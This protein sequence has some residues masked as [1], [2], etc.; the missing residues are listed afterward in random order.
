M[1]SQFA[2]SPLSLSDH[3]RLLKL[4]GD[5]RQSVNLL[6]QALEDDKPLPPTW[7]CEAIVR[8]AVQ[9]GLLAKI[10]SKGPKAAKAPATARVPRTAP[11]AMKEKKS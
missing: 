11:A 4:L 1:P 6:E 2:P 3:A 7:G 9:L 5:V 10:Y 8:S